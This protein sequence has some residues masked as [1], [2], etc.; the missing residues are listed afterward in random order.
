MSFKQSL[1]EIKEYVNIKE[2]LLYNLGYFAYLMMMVFYMHST[3][4]AVENT[5]VVPMIKLP[6]I[7]I[8]AFSAILLIQ[9]SDIK[10]F[11]VKK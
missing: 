5:S 4:S 8:I 10:V 3:L 2:T 11:V 9:K 1:S 7:V 6:F